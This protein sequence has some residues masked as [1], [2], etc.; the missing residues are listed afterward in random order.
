[1]G[2]LLTD[3]SS[4]EVVLIERRGILLGDMTCVLVR[5]VMRPSSESLGVIEAPGGE[6]Q[7]SRLEHRGI[8]LL[9]P[10]C[11]PV[12]EGRHVKFVVVDSLNQMPDLRK[13]QIVDE[14]GVVHDSQPDFSD[15]DMTFAERNQALRSLGPVR[16]NE[17]RQQDL[18]YVLQDI[19]ADSEVGRPMGGVFRSLSDCHDQVPF[20]V[21]I[22][23]VH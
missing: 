21:N 10:C 11:K 14:D 6:E 2:V 17:H 4:G 22:Q 8:V 13:Q 18:R 9:V 16:I 19:F 23:D 20:G 1:M 7:L 12:V 3:Q 15:G 5:E